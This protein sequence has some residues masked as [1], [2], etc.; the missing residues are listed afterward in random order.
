[1]TMLLSL[2]SLTIMLLFQMQD[3]PH[4]RM[5][6]KREGKKRQSRVFYIFR[7]ETLNPKR[8][9]GWVGRGWAQRGSASE[10]KQPNL[11]EGGCVNERLR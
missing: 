11:S 6:R 5:R 7:L 8:D 3:N 2:A 1:M 4:H 9:I 10:R